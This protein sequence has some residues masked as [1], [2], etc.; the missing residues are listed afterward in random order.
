MEMPLNTRRARTTTSGNVGTPPRDDGMTMLRDFVGY[1]RNPPRVQWPKGA[2]L[3]VNVAVHYEEGGERCIAFGDEACEHWGVDAVGLS[4][5]ATLPSGRNF[6]V[7]EQFEY[8]STTGVWRLLDI[9]SEYGVRT[10]FFCVGQALER[11][12]R[13]AAAIPAR[14][15]EAAS[16]GYRWIPHHDLGRQLEREQL[17]QNVAAIERLTG[18]RPVGQRTFM[19][20]VYTRQLL[21]E[22]G[23]FIY[24]SDFLADDL[25][26]FTTVNGKRWLLVPH[27][28]SCDDIRYMRSNG[29]VEPEEFFLYLKETFERLYQE[30]AKVPKMMTV[31]VRPRISGMPDRATTVERF[32]HFALSHPGVWFAR[33]DEIAKVWLE[34]FGER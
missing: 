12:P 15:H 8:G 28:P 2:R 20:S 19:P 10:T 33:R 6:L 24:D 7:E 18:T 13:V 5:L 23:G 4:R 9:F 25:P 31:A 16:G 14:G 29:M 27:T 30:S 26:W 17:E 34:Q 32:I 11:N 3:A 1:S 22:E 21:V